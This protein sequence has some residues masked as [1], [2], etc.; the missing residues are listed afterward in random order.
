MA[1][2]L[3]LI[4]RSGDLKGDLVKFVQSY[5][6]SP[7]LE[8]K[9]YAFRLSDRND[10]NAW[11]M[12]IDDFIMS[13]RCADGRTALE[14]FVAS[15][16][17]LSA[18]EREMLLGWQDNIEG[19]FEV[20]SQEEGGLTATNLVDELTYR[21]YSNQGPGLLKQFPPGSFVISRIAPVGEVW[22]LSGLSSTLPSHQEGEA[23]R[24]ALQLIQAAPRLLFRNPAKLEQAW[25]LQREDRADFITFFGSD[26]FT[27]RADE[28]AECMN[29]YMRYKVYEARGEDGLTPAERAT[30]QGK[31]VS[32]LPKFDV[33]DWGGEVETIGVIYDAVEGQNYFPDFALVEAVF[34]DPE[35]AR[36]EP[37][38]ECVR[39]YIESP[40][41]T[42]LPL[43][44]L[45]ARDPERAGQ[46]IRILFS[47]PGFSWE[48]DGEA[49][50]DRYKPD[51]KT[52][53]HFPGISPIGDRLVRATRSRRSV[54]PPA[55]GRNALC[56]CGS[57][58][59]YKKCC[60]R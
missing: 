36:A 25:K 19:V 55:L 50:L 11:I 4:A 47:E 37:Y 35:L 59:K 52:M 56:P 24:I 8:P 2:N 16:P 51:D 42:P 18:E 54:A 46:V 32:P 57:G 12:F 13:H 6:M 38:S 27:L 41:L 17:D 43:R 21:I 53:Q 20:K 60:G 5:Q 7:E 45:A 26:M 30:Q 23:C 34:A 14:R 10:H 22:T 1:V 3:R 48:R 44:R 28:F 9:Q 31:T 33:P 15:R 49:L 29:A 40:D 39:D 58:K